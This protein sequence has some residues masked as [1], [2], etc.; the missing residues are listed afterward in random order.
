MAEA[1]TATS[2]SPGP[3]SGSA[4]SS[5][6]RDLRGSLSFDGDALEHLDLVL[7][8]GRGAVGVGELEGAKSSGRRSRVS[9]AMDRVE[10]VLHVGSW[11]GQVS[12][13]VGRDITHG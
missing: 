9:A 7:V 5:T 13:W 4:T 12:D 2:A 8:D 10:D 6:W 1:I 3:S 11:V